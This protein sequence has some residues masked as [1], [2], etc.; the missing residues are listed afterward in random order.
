MPGR[1]R[2]M[3]IL[4]IDAGQAITKKKPMAKRIPCDS[5]FPLTRFSNEQQLEQQP[6][7]QDD[8]GSVPPETVYS[9][10]NGSTS[11]EPVALEAHGCGEKLESM[12][13]L[14]NI[15]CQPCAVDPPESELYCCQVC[16]YESASIGRKEFMGHMFTHALVKPLCCDGM[17]CGYEA[18]N[19]SD[20]LKHMRTHQQVIYKDD[21]K[22]HY[23]CTIFGCDFCTS[24][25][26]E[27][28]THLLTHFR[29]AQYEC[30]AP[31]CGFITRNKDGFSCH[32]CSQHAMCKPPYRCTTPGCDYGTF[33]KGV[34]TKHMRRHEG[35][36]KRYRCNIQGCGY[37]ADCMGNFNAHMRVHACK[38]SLLCNATGCGFS[39]LSVAS[40][41]LHMQTHTVVD[42]KSG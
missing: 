14:S 20:L 18:L 15:V 3:H 38:K 5:R 22:A 28:D 17:H 2:G 4:S 30:T 33:R 7:I 24:I 25:K 31:G 23:Y 32:M 21:W 40:L 39:T 13:N 35:V 41:K 6:P 36:Q 42:S 11:S 29:G 8:P 1:K 16:G 34:F 26:R 10:T 12:T 37:K 19:R 9:K 27:F